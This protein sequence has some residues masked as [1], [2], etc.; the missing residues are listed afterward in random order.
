MSS[1]NQNCIA[2]WLRCTARDTSPPDAKSRTILQS[3]RYLNIKDIANKM[4]PVVFLWL[5]GKELLIC[6]FAV[7]LFNFSLNHLETA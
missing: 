4:T 2:N 7:T 3:L 1:K 6:S 5:F